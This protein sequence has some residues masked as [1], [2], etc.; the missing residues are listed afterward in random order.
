[1]K[2]NMIRSLLTSANF[3]LVLSVLLLPGCGYNVGSIMHPQ[4]K[5]IAIAPITNETM[6]PLCS[7]YMR[8]AL[9]EQ[10]QFDGSL[11]VKGLKE[12]DCII[13]GR[14]LNIKIVA[15]ANQSYD[16]EQ[17]YTPS[18]WRIEVKFEFTVLIPGREKPLINNRQVFGT[19]TFQ[20]MSD[21][22]VTRRL[23]VEQAC[24]NAAQQA[25]SYTVEA[26]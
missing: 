13:Y 16:G 4:V 22:E 21:H 7:T 10:Y 9:S 3:A 17:R 19:A 18:E 6:E 20:V 5:S 2:K 23:G 8:Q 24:R 15:T 1:M 11:K 25:V 14:V 12:A 26:W